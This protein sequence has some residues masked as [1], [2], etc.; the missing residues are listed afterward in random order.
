MNHVRALV[1][2]LATA[3]VVQPS[4]AQVPAR[5]PST[6]LR[7]VLPADGNLRA[8]RTVVR[9]AIKVLAAKGLV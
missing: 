3:L 7:E 2:L 6:R 8:S 4:S 9:E 5:D 1:L